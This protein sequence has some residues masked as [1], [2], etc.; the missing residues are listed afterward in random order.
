MKPTGFA[1]LAVA[2]AAACA[3]AQAP[4]S[5]TCKSA[6]WS[7]F[8]F[9]VG[10]WEANFK[11]GDG[12]P[13]KSRNR[14]S[15]ILDGCVILEQFDGPPGTPLIGHS[16]STWDRA[17][18]RWKQTWVDNAGSYLDFVGEW[19]DGKM[20]L[21]REVERK[22]KRVRQR[23]VWQ[24]IKP[25]AFKWLWQRSDDEGASWKTLWEIDYRRLK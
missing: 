25:E 2:L 7:Q 3:F 13:A 11:G 20:I 8:D 1:C 14:V 15:R 23:M 9:W 6:E 17:A 22:G 24:D 5:P 4:A 12:K 21:G 16:V 10:D 19:R 18:G